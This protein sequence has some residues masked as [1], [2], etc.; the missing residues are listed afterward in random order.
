[1]KRKINLEQ[2]FTTKENAEFC[3]SKLE[4]S[5]YEK[6]I[7]PSAGE[8]SFSNLIDCIA[9][10]IEPRSEN[11]IKQDFLL[12]DT[13]NFTG[14]ILVVGNPPFGR[15]SA[16]AIKFINKAA[17]FA[18][19]IAFILPNS[20]RKESFMK[21]IDKHLFL[22]NNYELPNNTFYFNNSFFNIPCSFFVFEKKKGER[23]I[24]KLPKI[25][26]FEFTTKENADDSIRR[27]GFYAGRIEGIN[28]SESSH[29]F[30]K[31]KTP[32]A[33]EKYLNLT[34]DFN[35]TVGAKSLAKSEIIKKYYNTYC[36]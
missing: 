18:K 10:D 26:D 15:Q 34:F 1:M 5:S 25:N 24:E 4:L 31:W 19:T 30:I 21:R 36:I 29:Y 9:Y 22:I 7:E 27:V 33:K 8:G 20:F 35:N 32:E 16:L 17:T 23:I 3:L 11:I 6:I 28:V 13:S 2:F 12:L 14:N